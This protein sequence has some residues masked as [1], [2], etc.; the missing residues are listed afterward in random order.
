[1]ETQQILQNFFEAENSRDWT[2][3]KKFLHPEVVWQ[4]FNNGVQNIKGTDE[5]MQFIKNAY[6]NT[7]I[8]FTCKDMKISN[9]GNRIA[10][11]LINDKGN[12]SIDIFV[13]KDNLIYR[14]YE[15]ILD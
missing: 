2:A 4:L 3:Y 9:S 12:I 13:F 14:E 15:F 1:M 6:K 10:A 7:D 11:Y 5:Y 8:K